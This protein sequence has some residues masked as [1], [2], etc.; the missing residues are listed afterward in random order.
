MKIPGTLILLSLCA[1]SS[2][3]AETV[4]KWTDEQ[5]VVHFTEESLVPDGISAEAVEL[6]DPPVNDG[7]VES[8]LDRIK[9]KAES[10]EQDRKQRAA[11]AEAKE[12]AR[13]LEEA[14]Q[15]D[16]IVEAPPKKKKKR[17]SSNRQ[18]T[19]PAP[20]PPAPAPPP[21]PAFNQ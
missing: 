20:P 9:K 15:R 8:T 2:A 19:Q 18:R 7:E 16:E 10:L 21:P 5:G 14:L 1:I 13:A 3:A 6:P 17:R 11:E 4:Y 12:N